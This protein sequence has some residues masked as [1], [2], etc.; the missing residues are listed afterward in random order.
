MHFTISYLADHSEYVQLLCDWHFAQWSY[1]APGKS[2]E[3]RLVRLRAAC[4]HSEIPTVVVAHNETGLLGSAML[5]TN[6][7]NT[8]PELSP[9]L[10]GVYVDEPFRKRGIGTGLV[11][12]IMHLAA[13]LNVAKLYLYTPDQEHFYKRLGWQTL[14]MTEFR[15]TEVTIMVSDLASP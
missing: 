5:V 6:D 7:M 2:K 11:K 3:D 12:H 4:G 13:E 1:L 8:R 10:A 9:W 14:E 15:N